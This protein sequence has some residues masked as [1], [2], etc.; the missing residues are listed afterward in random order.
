MGHKLSQTQHH[1][2]HNH[3]RDQGMD[4]GDCDCDKGQNVGDWIS[5]LCSEIQDREIVQT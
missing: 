5:H 2:R 1:S 3:I 4:F